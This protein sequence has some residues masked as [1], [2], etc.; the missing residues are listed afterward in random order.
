MI[1]LIKNAV[2]ALSVHG[3]LYVRL[4]RQKDRIVIEVEDNGK[5]I[6]R[7]KI[8]K[9]FDPYFTTKEDSMGLGLYMSKIIIEKHMRG[10]ISV[11]NMRQGGVRFTIYFFDTS[12]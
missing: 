1:N 6:D 10:E 4:Y 5:G 7:Q 8:D 2:D 12:G 9:I 11:R 3:K